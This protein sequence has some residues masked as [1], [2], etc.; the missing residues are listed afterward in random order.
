MTPTIEELKEALAAYEFDTYCPDEFYNKFGNTIRAALQ[1]AIEIKRGEKV[2][3]P[4]KPTEKQTQAGLS[5]LPFDIKDETKKH[6]EHYKTTEK[7]VR[8]I[9]MVEGVYTAMI[10]AAQEAADG[11]DN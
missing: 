10:T 5:A 4:R 8:N 6:D 11:S 3:V 1:Q 2:V 9:F 7:T